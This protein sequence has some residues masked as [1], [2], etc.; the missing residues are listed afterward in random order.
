MDL[1]VQSSQ[2]ISG[3]VQDFVAAVQGQQ[4]VAPAVVAELEVLWAP[5]RE[6]AAQAAER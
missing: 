2:Q 3:V 6:L 1:I 4:A 5:Q